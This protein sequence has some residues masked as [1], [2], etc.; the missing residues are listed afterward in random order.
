MPDIIPFDVG[1]IEVVVFDVDGTLYRK[2]IEYTPG[3][4][5]VQT[6]HDFFR[7]LA[8]QRL[9]TQ[10]AVPSE[11][12]QRLI[13]EY[14]QRVE[15]GTLVDV[16]A[17]IPDEIRGDYTGLVNHYGSN[18]KVFL[19][20]FG[21][22]SSFLQQMLSHIKFDTILG[23]DPR[24]QK[25]FD[26]LRQRGYR[27][28]ILTTEVYDTVAQVAD[29]VGFQLGQFDMDTGDNYRILCAE[30]VTDKKP[31]PEGFHRIVE[32]YGVQNPRS[33]VYVGDHFGKDVEAPL[34]AGLQAVHVDPNHP[35]K[36]I[37]VADIENGRFEFAKINEV[38]AITELL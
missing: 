11:V 31:S 25:T 17:S 15:D 13:D 8:F 26:T 6:A 7:F 1:S 16:V 36:G 22:E 35:K 23:A 38:S 19:N 29:V 32:L 10:G 4:G 28:G 12:S 30:N 5:S 18:G 2:D 34:K 9:R 24:L 3:H 37:G 33:V 20:K 27:L 21:T 14:G